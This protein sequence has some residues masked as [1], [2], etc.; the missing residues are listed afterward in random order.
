VDGALSLAWCRDE[1][2]IAEAQRRDGLYA[3]ITNMSPQRCSTDR[4]LALYKDQFLSERAHH[5]LKGPLAVRPVFLKN[6]ERAAALVQVCSFALLVYG[7]VEAD[8]R[9][10]IAP[11]HTIK[12]LLPEGRAARPTAA[13]IFAAFAGAGYQRARTTKGLEYIPDPI[14]PAQAAILKALGIAFILPPAAKK[15]TQ[16]CGIRG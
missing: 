4:L 6:N 13:N 14:T 16:R 2:A 9:A 11:A 15:S 3:L 1:A 8:V 12:A 5:F 10:A 7:L